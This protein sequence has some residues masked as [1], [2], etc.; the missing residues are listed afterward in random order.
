MVIAV[1]ILGNQASFQNIGQNGAPEK[2]T[3]NICI[4]L[5][6]PKHWDTDTHYFVSKFPADWFQHSGC[7]KT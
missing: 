4:L 6:L 7:I 1:T 2:L 5:Q 3:V